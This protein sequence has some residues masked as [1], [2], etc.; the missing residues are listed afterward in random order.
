MGRKNNIKIQHN[1]RQSKEHSP[2][3]RRVLDDIGNVSQRS[4]DMTTVEI[5]RNTALRE[6]PV[7]KVN[8]L[9]DIL[10]RKNSELLCSR[11]LIDYLK[12]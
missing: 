1:L 7:D 11:K 4:V 5:V 6:T 3:N 10:D 2:E 12:N 9:L 8:Y